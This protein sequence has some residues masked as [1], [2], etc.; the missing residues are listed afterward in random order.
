MLNPKG[1][2]KSNINPLPVSFEWK[3]HHTKLVA[4]RYSSGCL[5]VNIHPSNLQ[6]EDIHQKTQGVFMQNFMP[7]TTDQSELFATSTFE[8]TLLTYLDSYNL[9]TQYDL[10]PG[11]NHVGSPTTLVSH[12]ELYHYPTALSI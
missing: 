11:N 5:R 9:S 12:L 7:K 1:Q 4:K 10:K 2:P 6:Y 3:T 8:E